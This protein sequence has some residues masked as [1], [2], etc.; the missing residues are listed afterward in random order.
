MILFPTSVRISSM[1]S[2]IIGRIAQ[3]TAIPESSVA[4]AVSLFEKGFTGPFIVHY[5]KEVTGSLD[6]N[7]VRA[8][9][10]RMIY[11]REL[12]DQQ[13]ALLKVIAE[14]GKLTDQLREKVESCFTRA[15]LDDLHHQFRPRKKSRAAEAIEKGLEPLAEYFW[16][17]EVD[18]WSVEEHVNVFVD[19]AKGVTTREQALQGVV[20]IIAEWIWGNLDHRRTLREMLWNEGFVVS[21]VVPA[22][23]GQKTKYNMYYER[24]ESVKTIPSHRVLAIRRGCKEGILISSIEGDNARAIEFLLNS[25]IKD[26]ESVFAPVLEAAVRESY[27]RILRP[28]VETKVRAQLKEKADREA[29]RVFQENLSNL[30][31]SPPAGRIV[32]MG[33]DWGKGDE[34]SVAVVD[35]SG[36]FLEAAKVRFT[37]KQ[38]A[39]PAEQ[40]ASVEPQQPADEAEAP[41]EAQEPATAETAEASGEMTAEDAPAPVAERTEDARTE[42][43]RLTTTHKVQAI[44][45][46]TGTGARELETALREIVAEENLGEVLIA[47]V[48]DAGIA[49]YSSSRIARE[50][51]PE[52]TASARCAVSLARRLQDPL[53]ELVKID[54]KLIGVG[55][56][57]HDV[58]Q[59]ELHRGLVQ[60]VQYC[61]NKVGVNLNTAG[62]SLLRYVSGL[63]EKLARRIVS[64][65]TAQGPFRSREALRSAV[66]MDEQTYQQCAGFLRITDGENALDRTAVHPE[67]YPVVER[68]ASAAGTGIPEL[69]GNRELVSSLKM[70]DFVTD[71]VGIPTLEDIREELIRPGRDPRKTFK[72]PKFRADVKEL[73]DL[74]IGMTLEGTVT[75]VT[76]FGA[77]VDIGVRQDGLVHLSQMSNRFIRDPRRQSR[78]EM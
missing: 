35:E 2:A 23:V 1:D 9:Q 77:F 25:V 28:M 31:L 37:Q 41:P 75:N 52:W 50:E 72:L 39:A 46:G 29:I 54:P 8:I 20:D 33:V 22:K 56:Y 36:K 15:E 57:Q 26:R 11:Y 6:E 14:Q 19:P 70:E 61:V 7:K 32:V 24:R 49:I 5:R 69:I 3:D 30:L 42:L 78:S 44:A 51:F 58:D 16:N 34:C 76:N 65:R 71:T 74:K 73:A 40:Q 63:N 59:K 43:R 48:N 68:M 66:G 64:C 27:N 67:N 53:S 47:A 60:T 21:S 4:A 12:R 62:E 38:E 45:I 13:E 18:A 55:Q 10:E 17:Q